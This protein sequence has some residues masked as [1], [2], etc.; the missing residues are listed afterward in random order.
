[1]TIWSNAS[2]MPNCSRKS[3]APA[4]VMA[5]PFSHFSDGVYQARRAKKGISNSDVGLLWPAGSPRQLWE[6][7]FIPKFRSCCIFGWLGLLD[8]GQ[9]ELQAGCSCGNCHSVLN[10]DEL[11]CAV[12]LKPREMS[13]QDVTSATAVS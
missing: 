6:C 7:A 8:F 3:E 5:L 9:P 11:Q 4:G 10:S 12:L 1:M 13:L 2:G